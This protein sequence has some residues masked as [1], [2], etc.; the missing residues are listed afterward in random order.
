MLENVAKHL[1]KKEKNV[2]SADSRHQ[3][4]VDWC[5]VDTEAELCQGCQGCVD[6][7]MS[8]GQLLA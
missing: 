7:D 1:K 4:T 8:A 3:L 6:G 5:P 2:Y